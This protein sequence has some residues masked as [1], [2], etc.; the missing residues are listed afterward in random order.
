MATG[1]PTDPV[2][3]PDPEPVAVEKSY[4]D[5]TKCNKSAADLMK[6]IESNFASFGDYTGT[7]LGLKTALQFNV[8]SG[9]VAQGTVIQIPHTTA[10]VSVTDSV[11]VTQANTTSFTFST[12]PGHPLDATIAFSAQDMGGGKVGFTI[13]I[14]GQTANPFWS[15]FFAAGGSAF[16]D[17]V[18]NHFIDQVNADCAGK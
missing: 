5:L 9:G 8:P 17:G 13:K 4:N 7:F 18:W 15:A 6:D 11:T 12:D 3:G 1:C 10:G 14:D 2:D 16:E